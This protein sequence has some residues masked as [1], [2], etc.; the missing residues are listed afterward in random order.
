MTASDRVLLFDVMGTLVH[1]PFFSV[2][3][4]FFGMS[5]DE[6]LAAKHPRSWQ[7]FER[8]EITE[9]DYFAAFF[10]DGRPIDGEGL[11][12]AIFDAWRW[13]PGMQAVLTELARSGQ[14][15]HALS[16]Y[17]VWYR[18][19]DARLGMSPALTWSFVSCETGVAKPDPAA[20]LGPARALGVTPERCVLVDDQPANIDAARRCGMDAIAAVSAADV[21]AKLAERDLLGSTRR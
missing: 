12:R 21:R 5:L 1:E 6:L 4:A 19:L 18:A 20:F 13:L 17:P 9:A 14:R 10:R 15:I 3:P 2:V 7:A 8:G 11:R 16:N